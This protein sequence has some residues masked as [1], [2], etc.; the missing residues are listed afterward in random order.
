[1][2]FRSKVLLIFSCFL[3]GIICL[4]CFFNTSY[5]E[6]WCHENEC[7][8]VYGITS[9]ELIRKV[10][11]YYYSNKDIWVWDKNEE[12]EY[13]LAFNHYTPI[14]WIPSEEIKILINDKIYH[15]S[16]PETEVVRIE[17][18]GIYNSKVENRMGKRFICTS[19]SMGEINRLNR[20]EE[21]NYLV[22]EFENQF[23]KELDVNYILEEP[24]LINILFRKM[25]ISLH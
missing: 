2:K 12:N 21:N 25:Y 10:R 13:S 24:P 19:N 14:N 11:S 9:K 7:F 15:I 18:H 6:P 23:I 22:K 4:L 5:F 20:S 1:M 3:L 17:I 16:I 8:L